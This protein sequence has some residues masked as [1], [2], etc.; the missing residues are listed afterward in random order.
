MELDGL[1]VLVVEDEGMIAM[2]A[3]G[4]L[5]AMGCEVAGFA[6]RLPDALSKIDTLSFDVALLDVNLAGTL[7]Y[8]VA[9]ALRARGVKFI[10]TTGY[11]NAS[12][13]PNLRDAPVL[14]KPYVQAQLR[15]ALVAACGEIAVVG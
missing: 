1:R 12:L 4:M 8:P 7:S 2:L 15:A 9:E 10:F 13:P 5:V 11:G 6:A 3:K 14:S